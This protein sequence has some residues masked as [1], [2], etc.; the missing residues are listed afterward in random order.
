MHVIKRGKLF[1]HDWYFRIGKRVQVLGINSQLSE[2]E[3]VL[4]WEFDELPLDRVRDIM[5][6]VQYEHLLPQIF[7]LQASTE[8]SWHAV[9]LSAHPWLQALS[10][11]AAT[12]GVDPDYVRL[13]AHREHFTL[14]LTDKGNGAPVVREVLG[15]VMPETATLDDF[16]QGVRYGAWRRE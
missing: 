16:I 12:E 10:I 8:T 5:K 14:R 13:A 15:S 1:G 11:V 3:S 7:L 6:G 9:C 4:F 2:G